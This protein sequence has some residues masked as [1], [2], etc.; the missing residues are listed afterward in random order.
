MQK[1]LFITGSLIIV[2]VAGYF[3]SQAVIRKKIDEALRA[4]PSSMQVT[5]GS[6]RPDIFGRSLVMDDVQATDPGRRLSIRRLTVRGINY[7][8]L[9]RSFK[10][11]SVGRLEFTGVKAEEAKRFSFEGDLEIDS[12]GIA[13][14]DKPGDSVT[15]GGGRLRAGRLSYVIPGAHE[16]LHVSNFELDSK[17]LSLHADTVRIAPTLGKVE[18]GGVKGHQVDWVSAVSE[19]LSVKGLDVMALLQHRLIANEI[20]IGRN[21]IYVF[22][23]RRLP[24]QEDSKPLPVDYLKSMPLSIR[25]QLLKFGPGTFTY[26]EFPGKGDKTGILKIVRL[27]GTVKSLINHPEKGDPA[28]MTLTTEGSLMGSGSVRATTKMPL[29]KGAPYKVEGAFHELDV[30][31]LNASAENLGNIHLESGMLNNLAF[32]FDMTEEKASG[33]IVG[34]YHNLVVDKL[35]GTDRKKVDKFKS[36]FL[37]KLIIPKDKDHTLPESKRTGKVDYKRDPAR[38]FSYY[39]L[40][41]LLVGIKSSFSLG[42]LLPG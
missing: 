40:H 22:R 18:L 25:V 30:T 2:V 10:Q 3:I 12:V 6:L 1:L 5:Y 37:K 7:F 28:Y 9:A 8:S 34:E 42:F 27:Q 15:V 13:D 24:L 39:L 36:F 23:D 11:V 31:T 41:P 20:S 16:V 35:R 33:K 26:E 19:D 14:L 21:K 29:H 32:Q 38:Y 4:L 17:R